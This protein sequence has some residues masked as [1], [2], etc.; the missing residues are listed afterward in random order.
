MS[1]AQPVIIGALSECSVGIRL[2]GLVIGADVWID[3]TGG[4]SRIDF[5]KA[6]W[7]NTVFNLPVSLAAGIDIVA[8]QQVGTQ[9]S[10]PQNPPTHVNGAPTPSGL[11]IGSFV[12]PIYSFATCV[13]LQGLFPGALVEVW[14]VVSS[15][16]ISDWVQLGQGVVSPD[17]NA[18]VDLNQD[19]TNVGR[20][21][22][23][24]TACFQ[25]PNPIR[26][27]EPIDGGPPIDFSGPLGDPHIRE[28]HACDRRVVVDNLTTGATL[29][30][31]FPDG[32]SF[33]ICT[34]QPSRVVGPSTTPFVAGQSVDAQVSFPTVGITSSATSTTVSGDPVNVPAFREQPCDGQ[35][36]VRLGDLHPGAIVEVRIEG[37]PP[38][39]FG[40]GQ[41]IFD[42][43]T[44]PLPFDAKIV[45]RQNACLDAAGGANPATW[46]DETAIV[47]VHC[48]PGDLS[49]CGDQCCNEAEWCCGSLLHGPH[50]RRHEDNWCD[51][52]GP[53]PEGFNCE[54]GPSGM[55]TCCTSNGEK[56]CISRQE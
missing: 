36:F 54:R 48:C 13:G 17:G 44:K 22:F 6:P 49:P 15:G 40:A 28:P 51:C 18:T 47:V 42:L 25:G 23:W 30:T 19:L 34:V 26:Q 31:N 52:F 2:D 12:T 41:S 29:T 16:G 10:Q 11:M 8:F 45:V 37:E 5:G 9:V 32:Q 46:S 7:P 35:E 56:V 3:T 43:R 55:G 38:M 53:C 20:L 50:C 1:V 27:S 24:Q 14:G 33:S 21:R 39:V 4:G